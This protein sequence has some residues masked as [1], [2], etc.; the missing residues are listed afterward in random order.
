M[1]TGHEDRWH[2]G[3]RVVADRPFATVSHMI[4]NW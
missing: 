3:M 4:D 2:K 1:D